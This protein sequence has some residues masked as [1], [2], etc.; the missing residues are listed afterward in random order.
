MAKY[1]IVELSIDKTGNLINVDMLSND[2]QKS[3]MKLILMRFL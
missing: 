2:A 1:S 3:S